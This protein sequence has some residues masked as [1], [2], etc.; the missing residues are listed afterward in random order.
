[1]KTHDF[2]K[3]TLFSLLIILL[4]ARLTKMETPDNAKN[5][6]NTPNTLV[7]DKTVSAHKCTLKTYSNF[8]IHFRQ[9]WRSVGAKFKLGTNAHK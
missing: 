6:L 5:T 7:S 1:M 3:Q 8:G 2:A 4:A 9:L